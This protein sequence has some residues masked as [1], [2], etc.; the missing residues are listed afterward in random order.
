MALLASAMLASVTDSVVLSSPMISFFWFWRECLSMALGADPAN[1]ETAWH[2]VFCPGEGS[3]VTF[4]RWVWELRSRG[5]WF[6]LAYLASCNFI[7]GHVMA[8]IQTSI[9]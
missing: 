4:D 3:D 7:C 1:P 6:V 2:V 5:F 8:F 9:F